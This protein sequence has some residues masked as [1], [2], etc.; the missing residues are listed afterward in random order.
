M[1]GRG[2]AAILAN[3]GTELKT[4]AG[5]ESI[6]TN[7]GTNLIAL[8]LCL[9][10]IDTHIGCGN[11]LKGISIFS[12]RKTSIESISLPKQSNPSQAVM[13]KICE[14]LRSWSSTFPIRLL[15]FPGHRNIPQ[16]GKV[17]QLEKEE[18][19]TQ[20]ISKFIQQTIR[21]SKLKQHTKQHLKTQTPLT[22]Y[23]TTG[24]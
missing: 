22:N 14:K 6:L 7:F 15:W 13:M 24:N 16:K 23:S 1:E 20:H 12:D 17:N 8:K 3:E 5:K 10:E 18:T 2:A 19:Q 4:C 11:N 9:D 21:I